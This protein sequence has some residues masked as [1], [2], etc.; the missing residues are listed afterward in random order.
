[1]ITDALRRRAAELGVQ[2][3]YV[4]VDGV[5][6]D[7]D[8]QVVAR[9]VEVLDD[10]DRR[11]TPVVPPVHLGTTRPV[12]VAAG[13]AVG[14]ASLRVDGSV[15]IVQITS[16]GIVLPDDVPV[17]CHTLSVEAVAPGGDLSACQ[18]PGPAPGEAPGDETE[19]IV[20]VAPE[21]MPTGS[22]Q[23]S[24]SLFAP[25][26]AL[27]DDD[28][29]LPSFGL[30][31]RLARWASTHGVDTVATLPLSATFLDDP[32]DPSPYSP[33][34]RLHWNEAYLDDRLLPSAPV[35]PELHPP[36]D[37]DWRALGARRRLQLVRAA[38]DTDADLLAALARFVAAHPDVGSYA[39]FRAA[40]ESG[41]DLVVERSH[42]LAQYLA[43]QQLGAL[44]ADPSAAGLALDLP[45]GSHP[46]GWET[47]AHPGLFADAMTVGAPPDTFF[48][49][50]Q[51]W[52]FRPPLPG[53]MRASGYRLWQQMIGRIGRHATTLRLDHVMAVH[54]LWWIPSGQPADR[55]VYVTYPQRELLAV[56][57]ASAAATGVGIVGENLGTV[58]PEVDRELD[59]WEMLGMYE[60]QFHLDETDDEGAATLAEIPARSIAGVR[61]HDMA[62]FA[63]AIDDESTAAAYA[64][65]LGTE[66]DESL[67][68]AALARLAASDAHTVVADLDDLLDE[69]RPHNLPGRVVPGTWQRRLDHSLT[70]TLADERVERRIRLLE[71]TTS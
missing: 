71:R 59:R 67:L 12:P 69:H 28:E 40:R 37:V 50:G 46:D 7:A 2:V 70:A 64:G 26:Y 68:D 19:C 25:T 14:R 36:D 5:H 42:V 57:A 21:R 15:E 49:G 31:R 56:I 45:I 22:P 58:P 9:V 51:D 8:P 44:A 62:P 65:R 43:D 27:W 4:D 54:R 60:E 47:W 35:P 41:G 32:F 55:G 52:G 34:S 30:L 6:H 18:A 13:V 17:G 24:S 3:T 61:T 33:I 20:V 11:P 53:A 29:P 38:L 23:R 48:T 16:D 66:P 10:D 63:A 1:M 39:R